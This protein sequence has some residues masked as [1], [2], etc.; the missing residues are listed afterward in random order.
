MRSAAGLLLAVASLAAFA[1]AEPLTIASSLVVR[2]APRA[3]APEVAAL[4]GGAR[5]HAAPAEG[6]PGWVRLTAPDGRELGF[7]WQQHLE[8]APGRTSLLASALTGSAMSPATPA[9]RAGVADAPAAAAPDRASRLSSFLQS[10]G[11]SGAATGQL[12][13]AALTDGRLAQA[14]AA[15]AEE[16]RRLAEIA[17][18]ERR[19]AE[20]E[21]RAVEAE[22]A[23]RAQEEQALLE[24]ERIEREEQ[25][26][27]ERR[28]QQAGD[29]IIANAVRGAALRVGNAMADNLRADH[30][31]MLAEN[32]QRMAEANRRAAEL[33]MNAARADAERARR[34]AAA[35]ADRARQTA[36]AQNQQQTA[37]VDYLARAQE[38]R[39]AEANFQQ[40]Q[41]ALQQAQRSAVLAA[42]NQ[43]PLPGSTLG[44]GSTGTGGHRS[45]SSDSGSTS[46]PAQPSTSIAAAPSVASVVGIDINYHNEGSGSGTRQVGQLQ[47][48]L[49]IRNVNVN[50]DKSRICAEFRNPLAGEWKGGYR[51]TDRYQE[52]TFARLTVGPGQT[53]EVCEILTAVK[54]YYVVLDRDDPPRSRDSSF[55]VRG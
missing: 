9:P 23:A 36:I 44:V 24:L 18:A 5:A 41:A 37:R 54:T 25:R 45:P 26:A 47:V 1:A 35:A 38:Q 30:A 49:T 14:Q 10:G 6:A 42:Q 13:L 53:K 3:D 31:R 22:N 19:A 16:Q 55:G 52:Q 12:G 15:H 43:A 48:S 51:L 40:Q 39:A 8:A 28:K 21:R 32:Q 4:L 7:A 17:E 50:G 34:E 11:G 27:A 29:A 46:A 33:R 2:T 20:A